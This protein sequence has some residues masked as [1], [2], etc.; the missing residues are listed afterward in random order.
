MAK[1]IKG[2]LRAAISKIQGYMR[3]QYTATPPGM[4][5]DQ[6][7]EQG[8]RDALLDVR[9]AL[10]GEPVEREWWNDN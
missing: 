7:Y 1:G 4:P 2:R 10:N 6:R 3:M 9:H 8:Y 5:L